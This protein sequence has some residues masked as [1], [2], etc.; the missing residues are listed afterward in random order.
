MK[1]LISIFVSTGSIGLTTLN[2]I[3]KKK[4]YFKPYLFS[5]N[6][7]YNLICKQIIKY[8]PTYFLINSENVY[9]K[10]KK[11]FKFSK[12]NIIKEQEINKIKKKSDITVLAIPGIAGLSPTMLMIKKSKKILIANKESIICGWDII[13]NI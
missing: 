12:I 8:K 6:K 3:D 2:I 1:K 10:V 4:N 13:R 5:A 9:K 11:K 7:N